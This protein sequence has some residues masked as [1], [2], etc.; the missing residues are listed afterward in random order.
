MKRGAELPSPPGEDESEHT[1]D[2]Q[3]TENAQRGSPPKRREAQITFISLNQAD[4]Q[5]VTLKRQTDSAQ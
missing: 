4:G 3:S 5:G 1:G 2:R